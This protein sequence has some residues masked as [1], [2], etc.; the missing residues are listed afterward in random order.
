MNP[1][2]Q[3]KKATLLFVIALVLACFALSPQALAQPAP[4]PTFS[5]NHYCGPR[6]WKNVT[7]SAG[8]PGGKIFV[9]DVNGSVGQWIPNPTTT[10][11]GYLGR[12]NLK[13]KARRTGMTDSDWSFSGTYKYSLSC[14]KVVLIIGAIL[15]AVVLIWLFVKRSSASR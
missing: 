7:F 10:P 6:H 3:L 8:Q 9:Q 5:P 11:V 12:K 13:A 2:I 15:L 14:P 1:L 4:T